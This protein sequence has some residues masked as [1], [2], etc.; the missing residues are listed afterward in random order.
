MKGKIKQENKN[1]RLNKRN[2]K[3]YMNLKIL[4]KN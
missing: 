3:Y 1:N 4:L 2:K